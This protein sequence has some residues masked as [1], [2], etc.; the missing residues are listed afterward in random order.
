[1]FA[2]ASK[3]LERLALAL[4]AQ[5]YSAGHLCLAAKQQHLDETLLPLPGADRK[6]SFPPSRHQSCRASITLAQQAAAVAPLKKLTQLLVSCCIIRLL[7]S[8][9]PVLS[10]A[11]LSACCRTHFQRPAASSSLSI[12]EQLFGHIALWVIWDCRHDS[13]S[14]K[15]VCKQ[16]RHVCHSTFGLYREQHIGYIASSRHL[17]VPFL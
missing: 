16:Q 6:A 8:A 13:G 14:S 11:R 5:K 7:P 9:A 12:I 10:Q 3:R 2:S 15:R 4:R 1:M 17:S